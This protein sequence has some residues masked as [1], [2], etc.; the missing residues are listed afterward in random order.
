MKKPHVLAI[1]Q[2][3]IASTR[4]P[5]KAML[6]L[7]G[8]PIVVH[9]LE[10]ALLIPSVD[11][12]V[13]AV[14]EGDEN[15]KLFEATKHLPVLFFQGSEHDVLDRFYRAAEEHGGEYI[16]RITADNP[17]T[18]ATYG[19]E[20]VQ[21]ACAEKADLC[22]PDGL[23]LGCALEVISRSA[24]EKA[25]REGSLPHHREH[26]SPYIKEHPDAFSIVRFHTGLDPRYAA[27]RLTVDTEDDYRLASILYDVL[28]DGKPF[29]LRETL[30]YIDAHP[31]LIEIN[32]NIEQRPMTHSSIGKTQ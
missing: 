16:A 6:P 10:R 20:A 7:A 24:L 1:V 15:K 2:A 19:D 30:S 18:D 29:P 13:L 12:V 26:V 27:I 4:L 25:H 21:K 9:V 28:Y 5:A 8:K 11:R 14:P 23:P 22:A 32:K 31:E 17:F 3:R